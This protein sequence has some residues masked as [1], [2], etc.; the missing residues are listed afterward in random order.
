MRIIIIIIFIFQVKEIKWYGWLVGSCLYLEVY[1]GPTF[2]GAR[3]FTSSKKKKK[4]K[5]RKSNEFFVLG[6]DGHFEVNIYYFVPWNQVRPLAS[7]QMFMCCLIAAIL[8][9]ISVHFREVTWGMDISE[10]FFL[11]WFWCRI[12]CTCIMENSIWEIAILKEAWIS[13]LAIVLLSWSIV[14]STASQQVMLPP[15][16]GNL[17][18]RQLVMCSWGI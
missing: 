5:W 11:L 15:K 13:S 6:L 3:G 2:G 17:L 18:R 9:L 7:N 16:A 14:I 1:P 4:K 10:G 12:L 8:F